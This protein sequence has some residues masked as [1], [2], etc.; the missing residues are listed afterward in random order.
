MF[1][2][3]LFADMIPFLI[4]FMLPVIDFLRGPGP[5]RRTLAAA[6]VVAIAASFFVHR[7][8]ARNWATWDWN[9]DPVH[10]EEKPARLWDWN[11][12]PFLRRTTPYPHPNP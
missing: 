5:R 8:G 11:D 6:L 12:P 1:G 2:P 10:I 4:Y 9:I 7:S 3:R